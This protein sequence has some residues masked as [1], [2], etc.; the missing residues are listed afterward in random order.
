MAE[1]T[2]GIVER[3][4]GSGVWWIRWTDHEG[5]RH[6]EKAGRRS[7][8]TALLAKRQHEKLLRRKLPERL[9]GGS[10]LTFGQLANDA[11]AHSTEE[12]GERSTKELALKLAIICTAFGDRLAERI[13]KQDIQA[14]LLEQ[15]DE[16]EWSPATRNRYYAGFS[17]VFG[18][19]L[20]NEKLQINPASRIKRKPEHN[21]RVRF[22]SPTEEA[23]LV[24]VVSENWPQH[25]PALMIS[26][27]TGMRAS[28]QFGLQWADVSLTRK[29]ITLSHMKAARTRH[30]PLNSIALSAFKTLKAIGAAFGPVFLYADGNPVHTPRGWFETAIEKADLR[31]YTWHCN[32][33]TFASRLVMAGVVF[34]QLLNSWVTVQY[35]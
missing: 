17:L 15:A 28:E 3:V 18:V 22:L 31:D 25:I 13:N 35:R 8:A 33:H 1:K 5:K 29:S 34:G 12:N 23:K 26:L 24:K 30:L 16:R 4:P 21:D 9:Q 27:H 2:I 10:T 6:L 19:A 32:R 11:L 14:W 20:D 7:D